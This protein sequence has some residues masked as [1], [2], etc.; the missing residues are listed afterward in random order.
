MP[1]ITG[2][3]EHMPDGKPFMGLIIEEN[4]IQVKFFLATKAM[5]PE[6]VRNLSSQL[7]QLANELRKTPDKLIIAG[8]N[9]AAF[10][11]PEGQVG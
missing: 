6:V 5:A 10:R 9:D 4:T 2:F 8:A 3:I 1:G 11:K 7:Q